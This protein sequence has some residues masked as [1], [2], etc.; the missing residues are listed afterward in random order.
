MKITIKKLKGFV[1]CVL[2][3]LA[4]NIGVAQNTPLKSSAVQ[5]S[6]QIKNNDE[7]LKTPFGVFNLTQT[8]GAV[9]RISGDELR[10][11]GGDNLMN[12][13]RGRVPGLRIVRTSNTPGNGGYS[14]SL[15]GGT[16]NF[17]IDGQ[18]R[19]LQVDLRDVEEVIVLSDAT[20]NSL[21][22]NLGDNG[23][24][25][26]VTNG[27]KI[28]KPVIEVDFQNAFNTPS[29]LPKL[30]SASEYATVI[31]K[32]SNNDGLG[33]IYSQ[34]AIDAYMSGSDPIN[35]P[36]VDSQ[37]TFLKGSSLSNY[38]SLNLY[39]GEEALKYSAFLG[40]SDWEGL[41]Q[42]GTIDGR[43]ITFRTKIDAKINDLVKAHASVYGRFGQNDRPVLGPDDTFK[44]I[45]NTPANAFPL[46]VGDTAY[47]VNNQ[48]KTNLLSE[49][50]NGG[51]RTDYTAN[52]I[53]DI[54]MDIDFGKYVEGLT[55]D[56]YVMMK[57]YNAHSL[58]T[59]NTP[60]L[61][62]LENLQD[63]TGLDSLALKVN[64]NED[65]DLSVSRTGGSIQRNFAYGGNISYVK[66]INEGILN[67]NLNHLLYYQPN[68]NAS[69]TDKR[70]LTFNL[71][72]SYALK[73][74]YVV[75]ANLN[76]SSS[77]RFLEDNKTKIYPTIG[78]AWVASNEKFLK[79][80]K[81]I[82]H[83]KFRT[84]Y[85]IV[86]TEYGFETLL[87]LDT[88]SG[89]RNNGTTFLGTTGN[90]SQ[91]EL[92]Y[93]LT[94]TGNEAIDWV[95][96]NQLFAG[97]ELQMFKKLRLDINYFD[98]EINNQVVKAS[99]LYASALGN[100]V[101]LP[102]LNYKQSRNRGFNSNITFS[103]NTNSFKYH[104]SANVG[105][106]KIIGQKIAEVQ[107]PD[108]YRLKQGQAQDIMTGYVSDGLYTAEN[109]GSALPQFGDVK[110][111]DVKY[112]DQNG[113]NVID[114]RDQRTIGNS[115]P[116]LNYGINV[117]FEYEGINLDIVG[118]GVSGY[119]INLNSYGYYKH[120]GLGSYY[121]SVNNDLPNGNANPRL[122]T[123][124][125]INN[126]KNSDYWLL[127]G[128][129]FKIA[130]VEL[131]FT[132]PESLISKGPI[133]N[134]KL[135]LRGSN[136]AVFSEMKDLDPEYPSA[137]FSSYPMMQTIYVGFT[138]N[139]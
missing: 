96:Y 75:F 69:Q 136:L 127:D 39:G 60:G 29:H 86:G 114:T 56:T 131:G 105:H 46:K 107:Y 71:N 116:R 84:S 112:V 118:M 28:S 42:I 89:G 11:S 50:E 85:G 81:V 139:F 99:Q 19:G 1:F 44:W 4:I 20:F 62:T 2:N 88:W 37:K 58:V 7:F 117:G 18:P 55:Y 101:Y 126:Y 123:L 27:G 97:I 33:D 98:I 121:G 31:N 133:T 54:G 35:F 14:Y 115:N 10:K 9:F 135:F 137:G 25:Y 104:I 79:D 41:E 94:A 16:P 45:T 43:D 51:T 130:N 91:D 106:N 93:R 76:S 138:I 128:S 111:G 17:L 67:L 77:S 49:L 26:V 66:K 108:Q 32:A 78:A 124:T 70:N 47:I 100:D 73:N 36:N 12:S 40:Y 30:L 95:E 74:K 90:P 64:K 38:L 24:I 83:L 5:D 61:Y 48:F 119:D 122:S 72:G 120:N 34:E 52:M 6:L 3:V 129:Y 80:S 13:L 8:T 65:L 15:N 103:E 63:I 21:L 113:D 109:I 82:D 23:L 134:V 59:N 87:Y 53:F 57:T 92:G 68:P 132:F 102:Q 22:G 110:I 125:S